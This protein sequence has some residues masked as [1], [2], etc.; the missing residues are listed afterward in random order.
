MNLQNYKTLF[1][2]VTGILVLL[3]VSPALQRLLVYPR[4]EFFTEMWLLGP[5][6]MADNY[7]SNI[8][9][10]ENYNVFLGIGNNLGQCAYYQ[11]EV[12][13]RNQT[14][15]VVDSFNRTTSSL[16]PLYIINAFVGDNQAWEIPISFSINYVLDEYNTTHPQV[17]F[18]NLT[19]NDNVLDL[20]E[21]SVVW[22]DQRNG[23]F[24]NLS[25]ELWIY[26]GTVGASQ[27]HERY[28]GLWLNMTGQ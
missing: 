15:S 25:F 21:Y 3:V 26:N 22:D 8:T 12:K 2:V 20:K 24:G 13:F 10:N 7:P 11:V 6:H 17:R 23:F 28:T 16:Q 5:E 19:L 9:R 27:Y 4:T 1:L 18:T 14:Q